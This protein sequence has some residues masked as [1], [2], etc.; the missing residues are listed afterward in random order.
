MV[1][2][3]AQQ[4][5]DDKANGAIIIV[6]HRLH[7]EDLFGHVLS[8]SDEW[9]ILSLPAIAPELI[10][11]PIHAG[12]SYARPAG[13]PLHGARENREAL[14][15]VRRQVGS[16]VFAAQ[17]QQAPLPPEGNLIK[18]AWFRSDTK[19][20]P[21]AHFEQ[22]V[23]SWDTASKIGEEN[24]YS[25]CT[26][27]GI[28]SNQYYLID[29]WRDRV[30]FPQL[31]RQ[32]GALADQFFPRRILIEDANSGQALI[33]TLRR[34]SRLNV[35]PLRSKL[36]KSTRVSQQSAVIEA[37]R[38]HL[39]QDAPWRGEFMAEVLGFPNA[40]YDD[41]VDSL[42]QFLRWASE[43][44]GRSS[45]FEYDFGWEEPVGVPSDPRAHLSWRPDRFF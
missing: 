7:Q 16:A 23:Q 45:R 28:V 18:Q 38:V 17:Y 42:E 9:D 41:Q 26:T 29:V 15:R 37:G 40:R 12:R 24:D 34:E 43:D 19:L 36:D 32:V 21:L 11:Y 14:E 44:G 1:R 31:C 20:P 8:K 2:R 13:E 10:S 35:I 22:I 4:P 6:G 30:E 39:P 27:W 25:V 3:Y 33:Q 5:T